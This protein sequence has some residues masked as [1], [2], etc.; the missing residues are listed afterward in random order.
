MFAYPRDNGANVLEL[1]FREGS[2]SGVGPNA[3]HAITE[4][5]SY[6]AWTGPKQGHAA[7]LAGPNGCNATA[8]PHMRRMPLLAWGWRRCGM[9]LRPAAKL[10]K[11]QICT[12]AVYAA[13]H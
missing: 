9:I 4:G 5:S 7:N 13:L 11:E 8:A 1:V 3:N 2:P 6:I 10:L 12:A